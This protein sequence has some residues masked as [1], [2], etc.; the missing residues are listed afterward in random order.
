MVSLLFISILLNELSIFFFGLVELQKIKSFYQKKISKTPPSFIIFTTILFICVGRRYRY[1]QYKEIW[2]LNV[3]GN[4]ESGDSVCIFPQ[5]IGELTERIQQSK[6]KG[7]KEVTGACYLCFFF[8]LTQPGNEKERLEWKLLSSYS[9]YL[10]SWKGD[11][12]CLTFE[13]EKRL[14]TISKIHLDSRASLILSENLLSLNKKKS[15]SEKTHVLF[16]KSSF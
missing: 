16:M 8:I 2:P 4:V 5:L 15:V 1:V 14:L 11:V 12:D 9:Q 7:R 10:K 13:A 3:S 6:L